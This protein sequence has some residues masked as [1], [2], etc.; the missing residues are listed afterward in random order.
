MLQ[1]WKNPTDFIEIQS[2]WLPQYHRKD[3][4]S[5]APMDKPIKNTI[6]L[7]P[8]PNYEKKL[9]Q[10]SPTANEQMAEWYGQFMVSANSEEQQI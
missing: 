8:L 9:R 7:P 5:N 2:N 3:S 10:V 6:V 1:V 4:W